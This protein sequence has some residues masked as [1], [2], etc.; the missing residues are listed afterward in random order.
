MRIWKR[1]ILY[2]RRQKLKQE[3][4]VEIKNIDIDWI[5]L[6][7]GK[8]DLKELIRGCNKEKKVCLPEFKKALGG[9]QFLTPIYMLWR[10]DVDSPDLLTSDT[11]SSSRKKLLRKAINKSERLGIEYK[12]VNPVTEEDF[13]RFY[14]YYIKFGKELGY[15]ALL[16]KDYLLKHNPKYLYLIEVWRGG[17]YLGARLVCRYRH[18]LSTDYRAIARTRDIQEGYDIVCEKMYF[19][20]ATTL[21]KRLL[22]RGKEI[23]LKGIGGKSIGMLW[24]KLKY[25]Y[26]PF[27]PEYIP[28][29]Y[30][31]YSFLDTIDFSTV[32]FVSLENDR[33]L[34]EGSHDYRLTLNFVCGDNPNISEIVAVQKKSPFPVKIWDRDFNELNLDTMR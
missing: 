27:L 6:L 13:N 12:I 19:D 26:R 7:E 5:S 10:K 21:G 32:F 23:N 28:F 11:I 29:A 16:K 14:D 17:E 2:Q 25:G 18:I 15:S 20:L 24:N 1:T 34:W 31:D 22:G 30:S 3:N 33:S 8:Q 9:K 4:M